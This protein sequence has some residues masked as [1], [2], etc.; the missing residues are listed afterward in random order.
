MGRDLAQSASQ[1]NRAEHTSPR[2]ARFS[3]SIDEFRPAR[4]APTSP[5][6]AVEADEPVSSFKMALAHSCAS[7]DGARKAALRSRASAD[8][9]RSAADVDAALR[10]RGRALINRRVAKRRPSSES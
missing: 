3:S 5:E 10:S 1:T 8:A 4:A 2:K 7:N 9:V 6:A